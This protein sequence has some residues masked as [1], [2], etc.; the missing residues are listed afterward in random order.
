MVTRRTGVTRRAVVTRCT[1]VT[2]RAG[3]TKCIGVTKRAGLTIRAERAAAASSVRF[4]VKYQS[5]LVTLKWISVQK[6][7]YVF[8]FYFEHRFWEKGRLGLEV[9]GGERE[10]ERTNKQKLILS[11]A[12]R[13]LL[14]ALILIARMRFSPNY[15]LL[16]LTDANS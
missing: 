7:N 8:C 13:L 6:A 16:E 9:G 14:V 5:Y 3:V 1:R 15:S 2:R 12:I 11:N 10:R 4:P